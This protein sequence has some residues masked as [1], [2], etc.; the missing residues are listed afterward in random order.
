MDPLVHHA[1]SEVG[2]FKS[3]KNLVLVRFQMQNVKRLFTKKNDWLQH[4]NYEYQVHLVF[5]SSIPLFHS[6][7]LVQSNSN[8]FVCFFYYFRVNFY[9]VIKCFEE[10]EKSILHLVKSASFFKFYGCY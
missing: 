9:I 3:F 10:G 5:F 6:V 8:L 2:V 7:H 1:S 4:L